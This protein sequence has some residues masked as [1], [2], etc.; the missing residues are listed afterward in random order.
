MHGGGWWSYISADPSKAKPKVDRMLLRRVM[1]YARPYWWMV[2][3]VLVS[4]IAASLLELVPPLILRQL[5]DVTL[6]TKNYQQLNWL[7]LGL[8]A[9]PVITGLIDV[10]QRYY[11]SRAGEGIIYDLRQQ[12]YGHLQRMSLRFFTHTKSGEIISRFNNDVIGAQNAI[13]GTIPNIVV[14]IVTLISTLVI[15]IS[16]SPLLSLL[17]VAVVPLFILPAKRV[18]GVLRSIRREALEYN[19]EQNNIVTETLGINGV[20]L[21]KTFGRQRQEMARFE[22][23]NA[24]VR[25][26]GV[27]RAL[28]GR[29]FFMGLSLAAA[30]GTALIYWVGGR[31]VLAD[32]LSIGTIVAFAAYLTRLYGPVQSLSN[33][34]VEFAQSLVSFE[35]VFEDLPIEIQDKPNARVLDRVAGRIRFDDV[36]FTYLTENGE[37]GAESAS[38][39]VASSAVEELTAA[40]QARPTAATLS[41]P[42]G[43]PVIGQNGKNGKNGAE[44]ALDAIGPVATRRWA[45]RHFTAE[46]E[47]GQLVALV[48]RS[49]AGKTTI[50]YLL[51]RLYDVT[52]GGISVDGYDLR[53]VT[54]ESLA[55]QI[56][57]VTQES[58]LFHDTIRKNLMY[59]R[60]DASEA[61]MIAAGKA[62]SIHDFIMKLPQGYDTLVGERGYRL[63]GGEKQRLAIARVILKDPRILILDEATSHLDSENE[64]MI[65]AALEPLFHGRTSVVIAH[66]LSTIL[67]ADKILVLDEGH[68]VEQGTHAELLASGGLYT[69]LYETQFRETAEIA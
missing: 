63:S 7:A 39:L 41:A 17:S 58:Y 6:P 65:Q 54:Q 5:I 36:S 55:E 35:R 27:R 13:T 38:Q 30:L 50:T 47:A 31:M 9:I 34:Q 29:W 52:E 28:V 14:N 51:P 24:K 40:S 4:I 2:L 60:P 45:L 26:I 18:A 11:G 61:E 3:I 66:R 62:A 20:L 16:I 10:L 48:G 33:V 15:M 64:A 12:M 37:R 43:M 42:A 19:G 68:L 44:P 46:I 32:T 69:M 67:A 8:I 22:D 56:G 23:F 49:G 59:A 1:E 25:D 57:I 53:D 21:V